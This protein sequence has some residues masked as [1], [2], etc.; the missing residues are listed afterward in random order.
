MLF[1]LFKSVSYI[2]IEFYRVLSTTTVVQ[3]CCINVVYQK[4]N[5]LQIYQWWKYGTR[6]KYSSTLYVTVKGVF[7]PQELN[8]TTRSM[9]AR[10]EVSTYGVRNMSFWLL[11]DWK[12][13]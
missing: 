1:F 13:M 3:A 4:Y 2:V 11:G 10:Q 9:F 8:A 6:A 7:P 5:S 12:R